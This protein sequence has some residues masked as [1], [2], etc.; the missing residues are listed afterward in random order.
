MEKSKTIGFIGQGWIGKHYADELEERGFSVVRY[1]KEPQ[2]EGNKDAIADCDIV[3]IAVPTPT[4]PEGFDDSI[5]RSVLLLVGKGKTAVLKS[6]IV[7]GTTARLQE[8]FP[9]IVLL[10]S[11]EFLSEATAKYDTSNPFASVVGM[12]QDT[13]VHKTAAEEVLSVLPK[14]PFSLVCKSTEAEIFKYT[15]NTSGFVQIIFFNMMYD[16]ATAMNCDWSVIRSAIMA[17][18]FIPNRY[19]EPVHKSGRGAGGHCFIKDFEAFRRTYISAFPQDTAGQKILEGNVEKN[20]NLLVSTQKD[21]D[22]LEGVYGPN[23]LKQ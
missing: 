3:L 16:L 11:P 19:S 4:T 6:T 2:Y 20:I 18:P 10:Y 21:L 17:D 5:I 8:M 23:V 12:S 15:H 22:L 7:P 13:E 1:A 9:D 14:A